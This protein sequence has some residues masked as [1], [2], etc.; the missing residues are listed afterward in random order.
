M[1]RLFLVCLLV[2]LPFQGVWS[3]VAGIGLPGQTCAAVQKLSLHDAHALSAEAQ[4]AV[5]DNADAEACCGA[6]CNSC[7]PHPLVALISLPVVLDSSTGGLA[8]SPCP[9]GA[10]DHIPDR[11]LR[12]PSVPAA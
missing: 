1:R 6:D 10:P 7:H 3:A 12:P 5:V 8:V 9:G 2:M 4:A 11:L